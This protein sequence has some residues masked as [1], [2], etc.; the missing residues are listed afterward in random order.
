MS[1][2]KIAR[3]TD[4]TDCS[5]I[6]SVLL[7]SNT[8]F[9]PEV[10]PVTFPGIK[11][12]GS[13]AIVRRDIGEVISTVSN[14]YRVNDHMA[15]LRT[16][17]PLVQAGTILPVSVSEWDSG[18]VLA[19]QF[20]CPDLDVTVHGKDM[21]SPLLTLAFAYG[22]PLADSAFFADFRW[23]CKNQLGTVAKLNRDQRVHHRGNVQIRYA[24][25]LTGRIQQLGG[26]L[27]DRYS[28]MRKMLTAPLSGR[29]LVEYV[30][31]VMK[32]DKAD[33]EKAWVAPK[34]ECTGNAARIHEVLEC[35]AVDDCGAPGKV[36]QA[37]N[38]ITRY[39][40]HKAGRT[41]ASRQRT[42]LLGTG[43]DVARRAW[44]LAVVEA[45]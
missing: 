31:K 26:E 4:V 29:G 30:G 1:A 22:F 3:V 18:A 27:A 6:S 35:Y 42:M 23:F 13:R 40:T 28:A 32:A 17:E 15:Q 8:D 14:R 21:V 10:I 11:D 33:L 9:S 12:G 38:A 34:E 19:Y 36:W 5:T 43:N 37:F 2:S 20:R 7:K 44:D 45:Q 16:L 24:D 39:Q 25:M 41:E